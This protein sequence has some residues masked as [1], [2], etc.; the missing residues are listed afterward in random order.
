M[1]APISALICADSKIWS[2]FSK[3]WNQCNHRMK[4][5]Q[6][7]PSGG[8]RDGRLCQTLMSVTDQYRRADRYRHG[9]VPTDN[10]Q[11]CRPLAR[12]SITS[13]RF[14]TLTFSTTSRS[15]AHLSYYFGVHLPYWQPEVRSIE[16][17][18]TLVAID[19]RS[20]SG[21]LIGPHQ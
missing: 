1:A 4:A 8:H 11:T 15:F 5:H 17:R 18:S 3:V 7:S 16:V 19:R 10:P 20:G 2:S 14:R 13:P 12:E 21:A 6:E 9:H